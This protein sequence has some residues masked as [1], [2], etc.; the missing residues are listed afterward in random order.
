MQ[1][2]QSSSVDGGE[3][4]A[5]G[6]GGESGR[7]IEGAVQG[8][9][10]AVSGCVP[11]FSDATFDCGRLSVES[12][13]AEQQCAS[14][15]HHQIPEYPSR[16]VRLVSPEHSKEDSDS[17]AVQ[18]ITAKGFGDAGVNTEPICPDQR[19]EHG[20]AGRMNSNEGTSSVGES[21]KFRLPC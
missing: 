2:K 7:P 19:T 6:S 4:R 14:V 5:T 16:P 10:A 15:V 12:E 18:V 20:H 9:A 8:S 13:R 21:E 1:G 17:E 11:Y 3:P